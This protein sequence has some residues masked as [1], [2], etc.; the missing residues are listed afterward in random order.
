VGGPPLEL[1]AAILNGPV[2][3]AY[4]AAHQRDRDNLI[5]RIEK[6]PTPRL[7]DE[8]RQAVVSLVNEYSRLS[9]EGGWGSTAHDPRREVLLRID[10]IILRGYDLPARLE[11]Q[12]L[13]FFDDTERP[14]PFGF[15]KYDLP[16][17]MP[18]RLLNDVTNPA[19]AWEEFNE[20]RAFLIDKELTDG[21]NEQ[22]EVELQRLQDTAD[23]FLDTVSPIH[24][25]NLDWLE[26][27]VRNG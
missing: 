15:S 3:N 10:G 14:V 13:D 1:I 12:L 19:L 26:E 25:E 21:L 22:E 9:S 17:F 24:L 23:R 27:R 8:D 11:R 18:V 7:T 16:S 5:S 6:I 2:A 20:R 4:L